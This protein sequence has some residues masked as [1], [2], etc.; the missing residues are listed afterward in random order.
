MPQSP[1]NPNIHLIRYALEAS[2]MQ[3]RPCDSW[4][5]LQ[6]PILLGELRILRG[7]ELLRAN[8]VRLLGVP[9]NS[10]ESSFHT[11]RLQSKGN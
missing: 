3:F 5:S 8:G 4:G 11:I 2:G 10:N 6:D 9:D 1:K 7:A